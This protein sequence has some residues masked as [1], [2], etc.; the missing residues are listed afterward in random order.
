VRVQLP[1]WVSDVRGSKQP[2]SHCSSGLA[3]PATHW[4][5]TQASVFAHAFPQLPQLDAS[6]EVVVQRAPQR[7]RPAAHVQVPPMHESPAAHLLP[8]MPQFFGSDAS[9]KHELPHA[10]VPGRH[11]QAP[12]TQR[13]PSPHLSQVVPQWSGSVWRS[14][15]LPSPHALPAL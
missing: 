6:F 11:V 4:P 1:Q 2:P 8:H 9:A 15:H 5:F 7:V 10:V 12:E 13:S 3:Q 14:Q